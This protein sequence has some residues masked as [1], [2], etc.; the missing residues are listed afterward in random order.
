MW[1]PELDTLAMLQGN[2]ADDYTVFHGVHWSPEHDCYTVFGEIDFVVVN[3]S[4]DVL[5][6]EQKNGPL[7]GPNAT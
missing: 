4:G 3:R 5:V 1:A 7:K 6:I 2:L